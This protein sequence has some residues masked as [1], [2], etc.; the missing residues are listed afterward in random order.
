MGVWKGDFR[1]AASKVPFLE[2]G[3]WRGGRCLISGASGCGFGRQVHSN[4][5]QLLQG[6]AEVFNDL[7]GDLVRGRQVGCVLHA[8]V[9]QPEDVEIHFVPLHQVFVAEPAEALGLLAL[10]ASFRVIAGYEVVEVGAGER[11]GLEGESP[12]GAQVVDPQVASPRG[13]TGGFAV[14]EQDVGLDPLA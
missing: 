4:L 6:G 9:T 13:L 7:V 12:V 5:L 10:V 14:E 11:V 3:I 2:V 1:L 8:L